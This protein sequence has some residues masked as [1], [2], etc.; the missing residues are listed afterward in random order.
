MNKQ[1]YYDFMI[2]L[3]DE[4][5]NLLDSESYFNSGFSTFDNAYASFCSHRDILINWLTAEDSIKSTDIKIFVSYNIFLLENGVV[6]LVRS[7][8]R[9]L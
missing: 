4:H 7:N 1:F 6:T 3:L 8:Q 9:F 5:G 2:L